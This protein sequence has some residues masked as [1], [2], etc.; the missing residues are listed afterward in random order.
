MRRLE[1]TPPVGRLTGGYPQGATGRG[2]DQGTVKCM[3]LVRLGHAQEC[4]DTIRALNL[5]W[6]TAKRA[7]PRKEAFPP[8]WA[9][10]PERS[11][12]SIRPTQQ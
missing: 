6:P 9:A 12:H 10:L 7:R 1:P 4:S 8:M 3:E 5:V 2:T 11:L